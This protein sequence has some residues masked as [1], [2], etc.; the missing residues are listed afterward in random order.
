MDY[1]AELREL[2]VSA[3]KSGQESTESDKDE[4]FEV[5]CTASNVFTEKHITDEFLDAVVFK[6]LG[7]HNNFEEEFTI[8]DM[9]GEHRQDSMRYRL[10]AGI[11]QNIFRKLSLANI[12]GQNPKDRTMEEVVNQLLDD[13]RSPDSFE[14]SCGCCGQRP[15]HVFNH[16]T[17]SVTLEKRGYNNRVGSFV[18]VAKNLEPLRVEMP[19]PSGT[20]VIANDL[21]H[22]FTDENDYHTQCKYFEMRSNGAMHEADG[23]LGMRY[24]IDYWLSHG[25]A[26]LFV[27]NSSPQVLQNDEVIHIGSLHEEFEPEEGTEEERRYYKQQQGMRD[28]G[29]VCTDLWAVTMM[30]QDHFNALCKLQ[31]L[32]PEEVMKERNAFTVSIPGDKIIIG[33]GSS[34]IYYELSTPQVTPEATPE[35]GKVKTKRKRTL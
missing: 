16:Q 10:R 23:E 11:A 14:I 35:A 12:I 2:V 34:S 26:Y 28:H 7:G 4:R 9:K 3:F 19:V 13:V 29:N 32:T 18:C 8:P 20:L 22:L 27:G 31:D 21:R 1:H 30:D 25:M 15:R 5:I 33:K 17:N 24:Q 6:D